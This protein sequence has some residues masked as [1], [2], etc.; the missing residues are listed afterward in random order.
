MMKTKGSSAA[1]SGLA[2]PGGL[3]FFKGLVKGFTLLELL[4]AI[5]ILGTLF[6]IAIPN[7][8]QYRDTA[9]NAAACREIR[10]IEKRIT[11]FFLAYDRYPAT[12]AEV[13]LGSLKDPWNNPYQYLSFEG[14]SGV[15]GMRKDHSL[16]PVNSDYDLYSMGADGKSSPP[17]TAAASG[18]DIVRANDGAFVG[19]VSQY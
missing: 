7:Y 12:L 9:K 4:T 6:A 11:A 3:P 18:D 8:I 15:G 13:G 10:M 16:V 2:P 14:V 5:A 17:F 1:T 19:L